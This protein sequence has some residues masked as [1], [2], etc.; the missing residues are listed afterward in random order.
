MPINLIR[1]ELE[2]VLCQKSNLSLISSAIADECDER[3]RRRNEEEKEKRTETETEKAQR[4]RQEKNSNSNSNSNS[5]TK[6]KTKTEPEC[7]DPGKD[8]GEYKSVGHHGTEHEDQADQHP[9]R[10]GCH[11][12]HSFCLAI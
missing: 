5:K 9:Q 10:E 1:L 12:L 7:E 6:T 2:E 8:G 4:Q 3:E 11:S